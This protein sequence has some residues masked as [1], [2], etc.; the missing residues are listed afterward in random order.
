MTAT[1]TAFERITAALRAHGCRPHIHGSYASARCPAHEDTTPSLAVYKKPGRAKVVD[2]AGCSDE[3][4]VLPAIGMTVA[5]LYDNPHAPRTAY[6]P[7]PRMQARIAARRSMTP[8]QRALEDLLQLPDLGERLC[9]AI[10]RQRPEFYL[11]ER[12]RLW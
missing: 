9:L 2:F 10:A 7:D 12:E 6:Q 3:V 4:D 8:S 5:D 1:A 11:A